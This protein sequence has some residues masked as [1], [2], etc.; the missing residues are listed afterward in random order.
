MYYIHQAVPFLGY[1]RTKVCCDIR[2]AY[3]NGVVQHS[4]R[5]FGWYGEELGPKTL[6]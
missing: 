2:K 1:T 4:K 3:A 5:E 6:F